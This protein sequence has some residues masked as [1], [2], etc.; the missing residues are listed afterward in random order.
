M[1]AFVNEHAAFG[2]ARQEAILQIGT[3]C[4]EGF[5]TSRADRYR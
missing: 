5:M 4:S 3:A 2:Q 1:F